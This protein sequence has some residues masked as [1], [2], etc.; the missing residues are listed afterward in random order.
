MQQWK[1][2]VFPISVTVLVCRKQLFLIIT[3]FV[4]F[5]LTFYGFL[6]NNWFVVTFGGE[7]QKLIKVRLVSGPRKI[8]FPLKL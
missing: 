7:K 2:F 1:T 4:V 8:S 6:F 3:R 5:L